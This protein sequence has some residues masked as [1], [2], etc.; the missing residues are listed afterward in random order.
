MNTTTYE[1]A[2][3]GKCTMYF[4]NGLGAYSKVE[5]RSASVEIKSNDARSYGAKK[6]VVRSVKKGCRDTKAIGYSDHMGIVFV[7]GWGHF[8]P[9]SAFDASGTATV[10]FDRSNDFDAILTDAVKTLG[11][12]IVADYRGF[13]AQK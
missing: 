10:D 6:L 9:A 11:Y 4:I 2:T 7:E 13:N 5:L 8:D 12:K 1:N 3:L